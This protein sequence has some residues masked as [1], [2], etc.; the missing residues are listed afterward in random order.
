MRLS[1]PRERHNRRL[2]T[3]SHRLILHKVRSVLRK[4]VKQM[5]RNVAIVILQIMS[6]HMPSKY[7]KL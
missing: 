1:D 6:T 7:A 5:F 4:N 3:R 2:G